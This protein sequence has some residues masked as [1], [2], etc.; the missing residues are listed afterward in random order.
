MT[1]KAR[2]NHWLKKLSQSKGLPLRLTNSR[3]KAKKRTK[4]W[5]FR[6][7]TCL[8]D[9]KILNL[10]REMSPQPGLLFTHPYLN[11]SPG[12]INLCWMLRIQLT[13]SQEIDSIQFSP[14]FQ[15]C[16]VNLKVNAFLKPL[17]CKHMKLYLDK[18]KPNKV[19]LRLVLL[20]LCLK[21][22]LLKPETFN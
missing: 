6:R 21:D 20:L 8:L 13:V 4:I 10:R 17:A 15:T 12:R 2:F 22:L 3:K 14:I 16:T 11:V 9:I 7:K 18:R 1:W 19:S 5:V